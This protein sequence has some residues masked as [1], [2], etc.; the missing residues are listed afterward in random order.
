MKDILCLICLVAFIT[1]VIFLVK[2][3]Y[4]KCKRCGGKLKKE[5]FD[6]ELDRYVYKCEHCGK[7]YI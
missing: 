6:A 5:F 1:L 2:L 7:E 3:P 4:G